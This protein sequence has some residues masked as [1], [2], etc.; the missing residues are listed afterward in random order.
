MFGLK[1]N[2]IGPYPFK[3]SRDRVSVEDAPVEILKTD[4]PVLNY[5]HR[6]NLADFDGWIQERGLYFPGEWD[7]KYDAL[8]SS[9][10]PNENAKNGSWRIND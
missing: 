5:P 10:D 4:H 7:K 8:I 6:I 1:T 3:L 9:H 2:S